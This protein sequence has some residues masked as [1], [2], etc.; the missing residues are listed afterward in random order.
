MHSNSWGCKVTHDFLHPPYSFFL[1]PKTENI[2]HVP[3]RRIFTVNQAGLYSSSKLQ[4][5]EHPESLNPKAQR[6]ET[7]NLVGLWRPLK[8]ISI[9]GPLCNQLGKYFRNSKGYPVNPKPQQ[10]LPSG[11]SASL[12]GSSWG[13]API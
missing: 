10:E 2:E 3:V 11:A 12:L 4:P 6:M 8:N 9:N 13:E 7:L 5:G 1:R